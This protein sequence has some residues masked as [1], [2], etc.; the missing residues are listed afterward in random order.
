MMHGPGQVPNGLSA[1][2]DDYRD[3]FVT[4]VH[5][6]VRLGYEQLTPA[7]YLSAEETAITGDLAQAI[8][9][10]LDI[11]S[12]PWMPFFSVHD[13]APVNNNRLR[14]R[15]RKR[16]DLRI[17]SAWS[18]PRSRFAFEAKRLGEGNTVGTYLG[19]DGLGRFL[20]GEYAANEDHAGMMGYVQSGELTEWAER[21]EEAI[22]NRRHLESSPPFPHVARFSNATKRTHRSAHTRRS[23]GRSITI[24]HVLLRFH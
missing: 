1:N 19:D 13:D 16:I 3:V 8:E 24:D 23:I 20:R 18:S 10:L 9:D 6:L 5:T 14:G 17:D 7:N 21:I 2:C 11:S 15:A 22:Q 12:E 4:H